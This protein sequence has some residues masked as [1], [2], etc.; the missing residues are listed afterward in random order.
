MGPPYEHAAPPAERPT[1]PGAP[2]RGGRQNL[3]PPIMPATFDVTSEMVGAIDEL[4][5]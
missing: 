3:M 4:A 5:R 2:G 1:E